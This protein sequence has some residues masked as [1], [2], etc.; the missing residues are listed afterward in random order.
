MDVSGRRRPVPI[1]GS[2]FAVAFDNVISSIG[3][4]PRIPGGLGVEIDERGQRITVDESDLTTSAEGVFAG[5]DAVTGPASVVEAIAHGRRAA[6]AID[7]FL[8]G[9]GNIDEQLAPPEDLE[10]LPRLKAETKARPRPRMGH[11]S[12][13]SRVKHFRQVEK[14]YSRAEAIREAGRCLR[15]DLED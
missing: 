12:P 8:G 10:G 15:C 11:L 4:F 9:D 5:G 1:E 7:R 6:A 13:S 3:Q 2:T 14:G